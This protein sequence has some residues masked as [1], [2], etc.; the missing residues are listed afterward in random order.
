MLR[1]LVGSEMC[2]RDRPY[3]CHLEVRE[4]AAEEFDTMHDGLSCWIDG[5]LIRVKRTVIGPTYD[6]LLRV[7]DASKPAVV[8]EVHREYCMEVER[9]VSREVTIKMPELKLSDA[10]NLRDRAGQA[11][12][13]AARTWCGAEM[14]A[15]SHDEGVSTAE[16]PV[17]VAIDDTKPFGLSS[18]VFV[19]IGGLFEGFGCVRSLAV[20]A[21]I[22]SS[23]YMNQPGF[24]EMCAF[25]FD[26]PYP[27]ASKT[28]Q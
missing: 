17:L 13:A 3:M 21:G 6:Q 12:I 19:A 15:S 28:V 20:M 25:R 27:M 1:S 5:V 10:C 22:G 9:V 18:E 26:G 14:A 11:R 7:A 23:V 24:R 16:F 8:D 2:I 4:A